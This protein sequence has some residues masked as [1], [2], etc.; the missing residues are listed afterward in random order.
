MLILILPIL[1]SLWKPRINHSYILLT[2]NI[3]L[4]E[5]VHFKIIEINF[6]SIDRSNLVYCICYPSLSKP[7]YLTWWKN[8]TDSWNLTSVNV[9]P[10]TFFFL[11]STYHRI[12]ATHSPYKI[13]WECILH[14]L[15]D[16]M[17]QISEVGKVAFK[18]EWN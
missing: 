18:S 5:P 8:S 13:K 11:H 10:S 17:E 4:H 7:M 14:F 16:L 3:L 12:N 15:S 2:M 9:L 6:K 1:F